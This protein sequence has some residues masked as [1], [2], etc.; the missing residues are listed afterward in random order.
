MEVLR[1]T[2]GY[3]TLTRLDPG[4]SYRFRVYSLNADGVAGPCSPPV[5]V[6]TLVE[7]PNMPTAPSKL[8]QARKVTITWKPRTVFTGSRNKAFTDKMLE[9][10]AGALGDDESGVSIRAAF[11]KYDRDQS[12]GIDPAELKAVLED[13]G[14]DAS[15]ERLNEAFEILDKNND[16][17][18]SYE[19]FGKWWR[20]D[21]VSYTLKRSEEV[22]PTNTALYT[23]ID[24]GTNRFRSGSGNNASSVSQ[25]LGTATKERATSRNRSRGMGA[26]AEEGSQRSGSRSRPQSAN[27]DPSPAAAASSPA[28]KT[29]QQV[30]VPI[31]VYRGE[32]TRCD[33]MGLTPNRLYHFKMRYVGSRSNSIL[34]PPLVLMTAPLPTS[35]PVLI[36]VTA[37]TVRAKWYPG[38]YGAFKF[39]V[40]M[41]LA[42][43][44]TVNP[45]NNF[46]A[47]N[48]NT[49]TNSNMNNA[50]RK[51]ATGLIGADTGE[52]G[53]VAVYNGQD[54][55]YTAASLASN[56]A[57]QLRVFAVNCQG[58]C[59]EPSDVI[60]FTTNQRTDKEMTLTPKNAG[61]KF[62]IE[63]TGDI[64]VGDV[65]LITERLFVKNRPVSATT[66]AATAAGVRTSLNS[67]TG[68][69]PPRS[70]S[71]GRNNL[72]DSHNTT[73]PVAQ[74]KSGALLMNMSVTSLNG[75]GLD[76]AS[77]TPSRGE[78]LGERTIAAYVSRD[79]YRTIR[80]AL[81]SAGIEPKN[82]KKFGTHRKLW[83]EVVWQR[84][85]DE[86]C[87]PYDL[88]SGEVLERMQSHLEQF[89]VFRCSWK[90]E[91]NRK[92]LQEEWKTMME[93]FIQT[94]CT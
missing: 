2:L 15:E 60:N 74:A 38:Q 91:I 68:G 39:I 63:C 25:M 94:N 24:N 52:E 32:R 40:H 55:V 10:W 1:T 14:V 72:R 75:A 4:K 8:I 90:D 28:M 3:G 45:A 50:T 84:T 17:V 51:I 26:I 62:T 82:H 43:D 92:S 19:E 79:N 54:N 76:T 33:V 20:R 5:L 88:K 36:D 67:T 49:T 77:I 47:T 66:T 31:V 48:M 34:S 41:R 16:G 13:L 58:V 46:S 35:C 6:H 9:E 69:L 71:S 12:G 59:S 80:D 89:E 81:T 70:R 78:Y 87:K 27:N 93:C 18:I 83:L 23:A 7:T 86:A 11:D 42:S 37:S 44:A 56:T 64:C 61:A 53:W 73:A 22:I 21:G 30:A 65:I 85:S 57:Y 29:I